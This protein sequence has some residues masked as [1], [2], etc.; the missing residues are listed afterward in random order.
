MRDIKT[1][2][3]AATGH[4]CADGESTTLAFTQLRAT[5]PTVFPVPRGNESFNDALAE[6]VAKYE[7]D[8][9]S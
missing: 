1:R 4:V 9:Q 6:V 7:A 5:N 8:F 2:F 3:L